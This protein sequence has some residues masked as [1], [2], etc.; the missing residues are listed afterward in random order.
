[1][2]IDR[3]AALALTTAALLAGCSAERTLTAGAQGCDRCHGVPARG[4]ETRSGLPHPQS[5]DCSK[6]HADTVEADDVTFVEGGKHANN[7]ADVTNP[8]PAG[9]EARSAHSPAFYAARAGSGVQCALCHGTDHNGGI[10]G[11]SCTG[12]HAQL[13]LVPDWR[14]NCTFCHGNRVENYTADQLVLSA[15]PP[16][17]DYEGD[18]S[19]VAVGAHEAH[20][21][22]TRFGGAV[23]CA[24]CHAVPAL[25]GATSFD[26]V[27]GV[28]EVKLSGLATARGA[29]ASYDGT[30]CSTYCHGSEAKGATRPAPIWTS[31]DDVTCTACHGAPPPSHAEHATT[32]GKPAIACTK[33]HDGYTSGA[34]VA[35]RHLDGTADVYFAK[36]GGA[37]GEIY[38]FAGTWTDCVTCHSNNK[39]K[40]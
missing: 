32:S 14:K 30:S 6:C 8:H 9:F 38:E 23:E 29:A 21:Y 16:A 22:S 5:T 17:V 37:E 4:V 28:A 7:V 19:Q 13:S 34:V 20:L 33:C 12:C 35:G 11:V 40:L 39:N 2:R 10:V 27:D 3:I 25:D 31:T 15:P 18:P 36:K 26:H 1:M 24:A